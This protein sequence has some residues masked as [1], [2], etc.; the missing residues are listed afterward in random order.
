MKTSWRVR[1]ASLWVAMPQPQ[2]AGSG[3]HSIARP[4]ANYRCFFTLKTTVMASQYLQMHKHLV[5]ISPTTS[6]PSK[7]CLFLMATAVIHSRLPITLPVALSTFVKVTVLRLSGYA[8]RACRD[9]PDRTHRHTKVLTSWQQKKLAT[10]YPA[11]MILSSPRS[12]SH[13]KSGQQ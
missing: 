1:L 3:Q 5:A 10:R 7:T 9:T 6:L 8:C 4:L 13:K 11:C 2:Q 12:Y